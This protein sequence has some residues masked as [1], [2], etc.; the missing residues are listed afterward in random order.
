MLKG[1]YSYLSKD[2]IL[3]QIT[4]EQIF[5]KY[6]GISIGTLLDGRMFVNP[7]RSDFN[8]T[9]TFKYINGKLKFRDW[10]DTKTLDCFDLV[11]SLANDCSFIDCLRLIA[12]HF[13]LLGAE[14][15]N[16]MKY[17]LDPNR[18]LELK[19]EQ[20]KT[21]EIRI[22]RTDWTKNHISFINNYGLSIEDVPNMFPIKCYW[23]NGIKY[24]LKTIMFAYHFND[25]FSD[26]YPFDYKIYCP[27]AD[28]NKGELK[29][30]HSNPKILQ[31]EDGLKFNNS[32]IIIT[33]SYKD[34]NVLRKLV[35]IYPDIFYFDTAATMSE[36]TPIHKEKLEFLKRKY[37]QII[38][39][40]NNDKP[41]I[42]SA[43]TQS[44][45][46]GCSFIV[47]PEGFPKDP[48]DIVKENKGSYDELYEV[49]LE[50]L[51]LNLPF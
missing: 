41:G 22:K 17:V 47:N 20:Q 50:L 48:S 8:P 30:L 43:E 40:Y 13:S 39:Y 33:S 18:L 42:K 3:S 28:K 6:L 11:K 2:F 45:E 21:I 1:S 31:G 35:K 26:T 15:A 10:A 19:K 37:K 32:T 29:F 25:I 12:H 7:L 27:F 24:Q 38:L 16:K 44:L 36:T 23:V 51:N 4:E 5:E 14:E 46:Y 49:M 34:V 9:C